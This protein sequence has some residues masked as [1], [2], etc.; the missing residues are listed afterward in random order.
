MIYVTI[1][2]KKCLLDGCCYFLL[3][4]GGGAWNE[5]VQVEGI[6]F[7]LIKSYNVAFQDLNEILLCCKN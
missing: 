5:K 6:D 7:M 4:L 2:S 1:N 3:I